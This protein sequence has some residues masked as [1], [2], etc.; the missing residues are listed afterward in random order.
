M[1]LHAWLFEKKRFW[2]PVKVYVLISESPESY[3]NRV[4]T[5]LDQVT[6]P[7]SRPWLGLFGLSV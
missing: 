1:Q 4:R 2:C 7:K 6:V 3:L 5:E